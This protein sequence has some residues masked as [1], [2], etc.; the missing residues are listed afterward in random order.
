[1]SATIAQGELQRAIAPFKTMPLQEA[2]LNPSIHVVL[3]PTLL[4]ILWL[5]IRHLQRSLG[6]LSTASLLS[7]L[8]S[9][10]ALAK[11]WPIVCVYL[12]MSGKGG[13]AAASL[14]KAS[15]MALV[16]TGVA[17]FF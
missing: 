1:M 2:I 15:S 3:V 8:T 14:L 7:C 10:V 11:G 12:G 16:G 5:L 9:T 6:A 4:G 13:A 17:T